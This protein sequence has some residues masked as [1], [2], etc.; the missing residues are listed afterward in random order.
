MIDHY[1][2]REKELLDNHKIYIQEL[3]E[4]YENQIKELKDREKEY[5]AIINRK[6]ETVERLANK[7]TNVNNGVIY[8]TINLKPLTNEHILE[9]AQKITPEHMKNVYSMGSFIGAEVLDDVCSVTDKARR[10]VAYRDKNNIPKKD[11]IDNLIPKVLHPMANLLTEI[12]K[13]AISI[14]EIE[15]KK[16][17]EEINNNDKIDTQ[18]KKL[19][20]LDVSN[21][22][23]KQKNDINA[24]HDT[25]HQIVNG[26]T[27][28]HPKIKNTFINVVTTT[29]KGKEMYNTISI[30][31]VQNTPTIENITN[32]VQIINT[33]NTKEDNDGYV[34]KVIDN[35][36]IYVKL[37]GNFYIDRNNTKYH[38]SLVEEDYSEDSSEYI[39]PKPVI[40]QRLLSQLEINRLYPPEIDEIDEISEANDEISE[41]NEEIEEENDENK[42]PKKSKKKYKKNETPSNSDDENYNN[43]N[44]NNNNTDDE[45]SGTNN[46]IEY[47]EDSDNNNELSYCD[48]DS[49]RG[50]DT[51]FEIDQESETE[52]NKKNSKKKKIQTLKK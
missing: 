22:C 23:R 32:N 8:N 18:Y 35:E 28:V 49:Y 39:E 1:E 41:A 10:T 31:G 46:N 7:K 48:G 52:T 29:I 44:N 36:E 11:K 33:S 37:V 25:M 15:E 34:K 30:E 2:K 17:K 14:C 13:E 21:K 24:L 40:K 51:E 16:E 12:N 4:L 42:K 27:I 5:L 19:L 50:N 43:N 45:M 3:K 26:K 9:K 47:N 20:E 38:R 6:D